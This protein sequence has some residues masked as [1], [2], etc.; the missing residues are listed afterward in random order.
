MSSISVLLSQ[1]LTT[2]ASPAS[3]SSG[4]RSPPCSQ[5][6]FPAPPFRP[7]LLITPRVTVTLT[8]AYYASVCFAFL[9][10]CSWS[11]AFSITALPCSILSP[12]LRSFPS[13][14]S[15]S[16]CAFLTVSSFA[17]NSLVQR[18]LLLLRD[19]LFLL[20]LPSSSLHLLPTTVHSPRPSSSPRSINPSCSPPSPPLSRPLS[21]SPPHH[22]R[23]Q[24]RRCRQQPVTHSPRPAWPSAGLSI[25]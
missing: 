24:R 22:P 15:C 8:R 23:P 25:F 3:S 13:M 20:D 16:F 6:H 2:T 7:P 10:S 18:L 9:N 12:M 4:P 14:I 1:V 11:M 19:L 21:P 17:F 5:I